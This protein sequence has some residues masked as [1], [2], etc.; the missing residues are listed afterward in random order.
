MH[1]PRTV[2]N[3]KAAK[4]QLDLALAIYPEWET[5]QEVQR[6]KDLLKVN[7]L[8]EWWRRLKRVGRVILQ[9]MGRILL[10]ASPLMSEG[11]RDRL[12]KFVSTSL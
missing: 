1:C 6:V 9:I 7:P 2:E 8:W 10:G 4:F 3:L 5:F 12:S 11:L